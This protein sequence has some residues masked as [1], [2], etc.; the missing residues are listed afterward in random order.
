MDLNLYLR[1]IW[2]FRF[3][4]LV[5]T[6]LAI[7][8]AF[9]SMAKVSFVGGSPKVSYRDHATYTSSSVLLVTQNGFPEGRTVFPSTTVTV[10]G[11]Q[12]PASSFADPGRL[13]DLALFYSTLAQSDAVQRLMYSQ[14]HVNGSMSATPVSVGNGSRATPLPLLKITGTATSPSE[15]ELTAAAGTKAFVSY[16]AK[17]QSDAGILPKD[18]VVVQEVNQPG[19]AAILTARKKTIPVVVLLTVMIATL[20]LAFILEN[21]RPRVRPVEI[22]A[23]SSDSGVT[24]QSA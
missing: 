8:L 6:V 13:T 18:R 12:I 2:R 3:L 22:I 15:A 17:Q 20:G 7:A 5:G 9:L 23:R 10:N 21:L 4:V 11:Q 14:G 24:S 16:L 1:V 19:N